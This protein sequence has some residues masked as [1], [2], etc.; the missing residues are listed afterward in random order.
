MSE[1]GSR[2]GP[3][4]CDSL[5]SNMS[6]DFPPDLTG[7]PRPPEMTHVRRVKKKPEGR[8]G[9]DSLRSNMSIDFPP[10]L[11]GE[12]RPP[13]VRRVKKK[14]EGRV[15]FDSLRSNMSIDFPPDLT[16]E[17]RPPE[18][19]HVRRVK[20][21]PEGRVGFDSLRSN[22]SIDFPPDLTGEPRPPEMTHVRKVKKKPEGR[23]G[24][25]SLRSNM[26]IDFPPD[27]TGEPRPPVSIGQTSSDVQQNQGRL[28]EFEART[29]AYVKRTLRTHKKVLSAEHKGL[30]GEDEQEDA[31]DEPAETNTETGEAVLKIAL[32]ILRTLNE[33]GHA[34]T[35]EKSHYGELAMCQRGLKSLLMSKNECLVE[36]QQWPVPLKKI[37]TKLY[38]MEGER[39]EVNSEHE[40][41]Q[42]E[43]A[44]KRQKPL[45]IQIRCEDMFKPLPKEDHPIRTVLTK[46]I[47]GIGKT[48]LVQK[49]VL[50]WS[51]EKA[52]QEIQLLFSL[53]FR[54]LNLIS[55]ERKSLM[56]LLCEFFPG[57]EESGL[58]DLNKYKVLIVLDGLDECRL[59]LDFEGTDRCCDATQS[60]S[61]DV[62]LTN[63]IAGN[64]LPD[65][66]LWIT[67]RPAAAGCIPPQHVD[68]VTE[69]RGF[70]DHQKEQYFHKKIEDENLAKRVVTHIKSRRSLHI[71]CHV[72]VFCWISS[73]V[74]GKM[75]SSAGGGK[76]PKTLTQMYIRFLAHQITQMQVKYYEEQ[77]L[78]S[79]GNNKAIVSLGKL[80]FE[81]LEKG[82]LIFYV[83][84][85]RDCG[86]DVKEAS[87]YSGLCTQVF[88]EESCLQHKVFCFVHLSVQEFLA[89][90]YVHVMKVRGVNLMME[91]SEHMTKA[92]PVSELHRAAVDRALQSNSG[93]LDLFL[94]FLLG[95]SQE[96]S[97]V[98]LRDLKIQ[99]E[100]CDSDSREESIKYIREKISQTLCPEKCVNL[101]HCL[102]E[103]ND[104]SLVED[105]QRYLE[106]DGESVMDQ[107]SAAQWAAL[108]FVLLTSPERQEEIH[109]K[110]YS[111]KAEDL[112]KL[113]PA[114]KASRSA[115]L[116][117]CNLTADSCQAV[118]SALS[119]SS[120]Q[121]LHL[122]L[123]DNVLEDLGVEHLCRGLQS[124]HCGLK[125][126]RLNRC[127]LTQRCCG[128]LAS[129]L[130]C[131]SS[132]LKELDLSDNDIE[133]EGVRLLCTGLGSVQCKLEILRLSFCCVTEEGCGFLASAVKTNPSHLR[134][135]DL[136]YN[137]LG[138]SG[139]K[140]VSD[141]L[142]EGQCETVKFRIDHNAEHWFKPGLREYACELSMDD[143]TA[144]KLLILSDD[145]RKVSQGEEEQQYP[146][147]PD[148][149]D[150]WT[151]VLF[152]EGLTGRHYWEVEWEGNWAG[153]GVTYKG[154]VHKGPGYHS[155]IGYNANSWSLHCCTH[156]YRAYHDMKSIVLQVPQAG[157]RRLAMYLD[158]EAGVLS[159]YKVSS[160]RFL[161]H[162]HTFHTKFQECLYVVFRP[163]GTGSSLRLCQVERPQATGQ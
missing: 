159:F 83:D 141:A 43:T 23:V 26:S 116:N 5:R 20:K 163:W 80:A 87:V 8:V 64:L 71:M 114:I 46:G 76:M 13:H 143:N 61:L 118:S 79:H 21:K 78:D 50:D 54:E 102:N 91:E 103:L 7:E 154:I 74:L 65:A 45:E 112:H 109:L 136:S 29:L 70:T 72:P 66:N 113:L 149:F 11:T 119:S 142:E 90:L 42:I 47:A 160:G 152:Q 44:Y 28:S 55:N 16:G 105:I 67:T 156:G 137:H 132:H 88:R 162:L 34:H 51:E 122:S 150:Y 48:V 35:L 32:H 33:E 18:M 59:H 14:P 69:I 115:M 145:K 104:C 68:R 22:M 155:V 39:G 60:A 96:S 139:V 131:Q 31:D 101:F 57:L 121:L 38:L 24:F 2:K 108:V 85:L 19:T 36:T 27:L 62:L 133:D 151:Q 123:S 89:A 9:F 41:R 3:P 93:H 30:F 147:H 126:L 6:I 58:K 4:S 98:L 110:K 84:D 124:P 129:V 144:H 63:L 138:D 15:G 125:T 153:L 10:D 127:S 107:C 25:D 95:L 86:I 99:V 92:K 53:P 128:S 94:R 56:E 73:I 81:Q 100:P 161:T 49:F 134:E 158:W 111:R 120:N 146:D 82:N 52:S 140:L 12:P 117:D 130:S 97:Q 148:R 17:P 37:Y 1:C 157:S 77:Q 75:C 135:L 40:V 106:S